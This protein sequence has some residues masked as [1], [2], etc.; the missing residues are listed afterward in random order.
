MDSIAGRELGTALARYFLSMCDSATPRKFKFESR[1]YAP[2]SGDKSLDFNWA[3]F[4]SE[5]LS[6]TVTAPVSLTWLW[7]EVIAEWT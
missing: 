7:G 2:V 3:T 5:S 1:S 4:L 6:L